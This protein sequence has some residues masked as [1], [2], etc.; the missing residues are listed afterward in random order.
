M[1][2]VTP[3]ISCLYGPCAERPDVV[4]YA[5]RTR[6]VHPSAGADDVTYG[7]DSSTWNEW[8]KYPIVG[9]LSG[10]GRALLG[11]IHTIRHLVGALWNCC[12]KEKKRS[13][14]LTHLDEARIGAFNLGL[15]LLEAIPFI[16]NLS[17]YLINRSRK[18][19]CE[20]ACKKWI[21]TATEYQK[22]YFLPEDI[23]QKRVSFFYYDQFATFVLFHKD[24]IPPEFRTNSRNK[25]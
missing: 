6:Y 19:A 12:S 20:G 18:M 4:T 11:L 16:G 10:C 14:E 22:E 7:T 13:G 8:G 15:G 3:F 2:S 25:N 17:S 21:A 9:N 23:S 5:Y 1:S 24:P